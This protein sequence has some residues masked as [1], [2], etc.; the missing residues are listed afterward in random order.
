M[1]DAQ[2]K[3]N[4]GNVMRHASGQLRAANSRCNKNHTDS[5]G[6]QVVILSKRIEQA[7]LVHSQVARITMDKTGKL[8]KLVVSR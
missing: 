2:M 8:V 4:Q 6:R 5:L 1:A 7:S 3:I